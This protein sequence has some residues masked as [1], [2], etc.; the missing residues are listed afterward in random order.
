MPS[1]KTKI[2][3]LNHV[4]RDERVLNSTYASS[5][6]LLQHEIV[7]WDPQEI[8]DDYGEGSP[9]KNAP[10]L[11]D[12]SSVAFLNDLKRRTLEFRDFLGLGRLLV[13]LVPPP[14]SLFYATGES[15][16]DG[17]AAKPRMIRIVSDLE[18]DQVIPVDIELVRGSG[19][20][21]R[22]VASGPFSSFW[23]AAGDQFYFAAYFKKPVGSTLLTMAGTDRPVGALVQAHGGTVL[24]LPQLGYFLPSA[25]DIAAGEDADDY[26]EKYEAAQAEIDQR[27]NG[28]FVDSLIELHKELSGTAD[29]SL[30]EWTEGYQLPG[31]PGAI[32]KAIGAQEKLAVAQ[33]ELEKAQAELVALQRHKLLVTGT[34]QALETQVHDALVELGCTVEEGEPRRTDRIV[35]WRDKTAVMEIKGL[36]KS[37]KESNAAQLEKWVSEYI[38]EHETAPKAILAVNAW[39]ELPLSDRKEP[40]FP[41]Q[42]LRYSAGREHC[43]AETSQILAAALTCKTKAAKTAFLNTLF[44]TSGVLEGYGWETVLTRFVSG[45]AEDAP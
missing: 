10:C 2:L 45:A 8:L 17:T 19:E 12:S 11:T 22:L 35:R 44:D 27:Y 37:A 38:E 16:N 23:R 28:Q 7:V 36:T 4:L 18:I 14:M 34:G 29:G 33:R 31:E 30:P 13:V 6:S 25:E 21:M 1:V 3:T 20:E 41:P 5:H 24:L 26:D 32:A 9:Y 15:R 39:R 42:M 43:L 40:A